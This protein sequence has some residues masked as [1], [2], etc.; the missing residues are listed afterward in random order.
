MDIVFSLFDGMALLHK[1]QEDQHTHH[2]PIAVYTSK[3]NAHLKNTAYTNGAKHFFIKE[4]FAPHDMI[5]GLAKIY[6]F[7]FIS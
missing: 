1:L 5:H 7:N 6:K 2:I 3:N 4:D